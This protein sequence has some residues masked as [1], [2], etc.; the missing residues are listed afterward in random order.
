MAN[1]SIAQEQ[2]HHKVTSSSFSLKLAHIIADPAMKI[3]SIHVFKSW[4]TILDRRGLAFCDKIGRPMS[5]CFTNTEA[6]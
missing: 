5:F 6:C 3:I 1:L 4:I 2:T